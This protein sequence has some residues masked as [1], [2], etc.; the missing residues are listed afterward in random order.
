MFSL[1][2]S[3]LHIINLSPPFI[4]NTTYIR[5]IDYSVLQ[6]RIVLFVF[7]LL[8][9]MGTYLG[10]MKVKAFLR[11]FLSFKGFFVK[12]VKVKKEICRLR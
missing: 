10:T 9:S 1:L 11:C 7:R 4:H 5:T 2:P 8:G 12:N 6:E 3:I